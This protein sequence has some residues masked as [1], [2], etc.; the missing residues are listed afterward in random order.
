MELFP[1]GQ[2]VQSFVQQ[3]HGSFI[4]GASVLAGEPHQVLDPS[5]GQAIAQVHFAGDS[6]VEQAVLSADKALRDG[7]WSALRPAERERIL[8]DFATLVSRHAE[9]LAQLET[10]N[11]GKSIHVARLLDVGGCVEFMRYMAGW[12][13]KIEGRTMDVSIAL[14]PGARFTACTRREPVGVVAGIVP[15][16][17]PLMIGAW[18]IAPALAMGNSIVLKPAETASLTLLRL[19]E[20][21][22]EAGVPP[23]VFN[24][25][26]GPG[27]TDTISPF[28]P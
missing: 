1:P 19:A 23:G 22:L 7:R 10:L 3:P 6:T 26:T 14:P 4:E 25:T 21:A 11:Q 16:N 28:T 17:F 20:L 13:T 24:V 27:R 2:E 8:L 15:W 18:K 5:T 9:T 12:A